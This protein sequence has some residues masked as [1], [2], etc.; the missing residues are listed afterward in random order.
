MTRAC[1]WP[2]C[3]NPSKF[4]HNIVHAR[5]HALSLLQA[6]A[7]VFLFQRGLFSAE[8][9][10]RLFERSGASRHSHQWDKAKSGSRL[11]AK[12]AGHVA[13]AKVYA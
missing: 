7:N 8:V 12:D 5:G 4:F 11:A 9:T 3:N 13:E 6:R 1:A 2:F 10:A